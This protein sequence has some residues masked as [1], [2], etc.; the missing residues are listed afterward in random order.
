MYQEHTVYFEQDPNFC[1][2]K[3]MRENKPLCLSGDTVIA[4]IYIIFMPH[5]NNRNVT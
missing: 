3:K 5:F 4:F 1:R 2:E